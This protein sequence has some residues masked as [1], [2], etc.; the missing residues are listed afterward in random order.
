[1]YVQPPS[2]TGPTKRNRLVDI[3]HQ[4]LQRRQRL[5]PQRSPKSVLLNMCNPLGL[6]VP[7]RGVECAGVIP[8][9]RWPT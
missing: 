9:L 4:P 8:A 6:D 1:M 2:P 3:G 7:Q 5:L